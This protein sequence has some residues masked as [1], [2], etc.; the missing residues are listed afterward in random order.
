L[1]EV[2]HYANYRIIGLSQPVSPLYAIIWIEENGRPVLAGH[3]V[4]VWAA[5]SYDDGPDNHIEC[6]NGYIVDP[7]LGLLVDAEKDYDVVTYSPDEPGADPY[8]TAEWEA[9]A[10]ESCDLQRRMRGART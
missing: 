7:V 1:T 6:V 8:L 10:R 2:D 3:Q 4:Q 9:I 5:V